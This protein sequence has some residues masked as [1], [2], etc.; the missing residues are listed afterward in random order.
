[1][2]ASRIRYYEAVGLIPEPERIS[3][4]RRYAPD[5]L[6]MLALIDAAQRVGFTLDEIRDLL[7]PRDEPAHERLRELA[8]LKLPE[9]DALIER[10]TAVRKSLEMCINCDC[11]SLDE[12]RLLDERFTKLQLDTVG[13][14]AAAAGSITP[15]A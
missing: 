12:C 2:R 7:A 4:K 6:R 11:E 3:G 9:I 13:R 5:V 8:Q 10:A 1:M 14:R 15:S